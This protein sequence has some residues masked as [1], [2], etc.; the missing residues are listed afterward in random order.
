MQQV[1]TALVALCL[2]VFALRVEAQQSTRQTTVHGYHLEMTPLPR[3]TTESLGITQLPL[4]VDMDLAEQFVRIGFGPQV[5]GQRGFQ[6]TEFLTPPLSTT[7]A[8]Q[9]ALVVPEYGK[10]KGALVAE[11]IKRFAG[12]VMSV[13]FGREGSPVLYVQLPYWT[14]QREGPITHKMGTRIPDEEHNR[15]VEELRKVFVSEL[16]AEEFGPDSIDKRKIRI[17]WHH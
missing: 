14:H 8:S 2:A 9:L 10:F 6:S 3:T 1:T 5:L 4:E 13:Q 17:W 11:G 16:N 15:L 7:Q 12:R